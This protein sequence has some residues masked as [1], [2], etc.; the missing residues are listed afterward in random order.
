[1]AQVRRMVED[2][3]HRGRWQ[4]DD[5]G[6]LNVFDAGYDAPHMARQLEI[7]P[8]EILSRLHTER[9]MRKEEAWWSA[10]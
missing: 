4:A 5:R 8:V 2:L 6:L 1:M 9:V 10:S 7:L 3:I